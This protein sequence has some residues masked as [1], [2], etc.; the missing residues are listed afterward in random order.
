MN[1]TQYD[2]TQVRIDPTTGRIMTGEG[3]SVDKGYISD[4]GYLQAVNYAKQTS[5]PKREVGVISSQ[6]G[7]SQLSDTIQK[8]KSLVYPKTN[9]LTATTPTT[10][11]TPTSIKLINPQTAQEITFNNVDNSREAIQKYIDSGYQTAE[12]SGNIPSWLQPAK[13]SQISQ[14]E[15]AVQTAQA[16]RDEA[17]NKLKNL[18]VSND[19]TLQGI[20]SGIQSQWNQRITDMQKANVSRGA[21]LTTTGIRIGSRYTGG[22][23]GAFGGIISQE[24]KD[25]VERIASLEAQK[26]EAIANATA[27]Y[28]N[29]KFSEYAKFVDFADKKYQEQVAKLGELN[30][31]QAETNKMIS[32]RMAKEQQEFTKSISDIV[33]SAA[34]S[35]LTDPATLENIQNSKSLSEA[36]GY[37]GD[38][39]Q[40]GTGII[41]EYLFYKRDAIARG[42]NPISFGAYE[43]RDANEKAISADGA[44][45]EYTPKQ[46]AFIGKLNDSVSKSKI[47]SDTTNMRRYADNV[48][49]ALDRG[50]GVSDI[51]AI[52][53]FQ[54]VIDEGAVT[55]DQDV[56]LIQSAQSLASSL[57]L[58][59]KS[60]QSGDQLSP[61]QRNKIKDLVSSLY[62]A[63][64]KALE[65]DPFIS[66]KAI[67]AKNNG[68]KIDDTIIGE[69]K[70][71]TSSATVGKKI[72]EEQAKNEEAIINHVKARPDLAD[73]IDTLVND[74]NGDS[75]AALEYMRLHPQIF[76]EIGVPQNKA[77]ND[78]ASQMFNTSIFR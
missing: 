58:K 9:T 19:P 57:N 20:L 41:G 47:Y 24:E 52:N 69:L 32:E 18:D 30:K 43:M 54:K 14:Q 17:M 62:D 50:D 78:K 42:I 31:I 63:Q 36:V 72:I 38:Y 26:Q 55:R 70:R 16:E 3:Q 6:I 56:K 75:S 34:K 12:A 67:E 7:E 15:S 13:V 68:V 8:Q 53:Q 45:S 22:M 23:G 66:S 21:A 33:L 29:N 60:L 59:V 37:A 77:F 40:S 5:L 11:T 2:L 35:G 27:A 49:T 28:R 4:R 65:K 64:I 39:L 73:T 44:V 46:N 48:L 71:F 76:G 10:T 1:P 74:L 61:D 51:A 25:G